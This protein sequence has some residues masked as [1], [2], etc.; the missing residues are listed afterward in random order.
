MVYQTNHV[1]VEKLLLEH[2]RL[3]QSIRLIIMKAWEVEEPQIT[4]VVTDLYRKC[5]LLFD[6]FSRSEQE[7]FRSSLIEQ[8][9]DEDEIT[10]QSDD[11]HRHVTATGRLETKYCKEILLLPIR[12]SDP[13]MTTNFKSQLR[14]A[15]AEDYS[16]PNV[17]QFGTYSIQWCKKVAFTARYKL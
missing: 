2:E 5:P 17:I 8:D 6:T 11:M 15:F 3:R 13:L 14:M 10:L 16:I 12:A 7:S 1:K 4:A 9:Q